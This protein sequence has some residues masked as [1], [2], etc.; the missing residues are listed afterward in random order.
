MIH[1]LPQTLAF[2]TPKSGGSPNANEIDSLYKIVLYVA[3]VIFVLVEGALGRSWV[4][5]RARAR[6]RAR[7][8]SIS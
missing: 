1:L 3:L 2:F 4:T 6:V 8:M 5:T 7:A